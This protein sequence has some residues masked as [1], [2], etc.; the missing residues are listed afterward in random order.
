MGKEGWLDHKTFDEFRKRD[1]Y[2]RKVAYMA[3][4]LLEEARQQPTP[5]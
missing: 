3:P 4:D 1:L 2:L 5:Q